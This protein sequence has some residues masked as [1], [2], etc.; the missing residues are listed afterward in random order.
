MTLHVCTAADL[1]GRMNEIQWQAMWRYYVLPGHLKRVDAAFEAGAIGGGFLLDACLIAVDEGEDA[2][3]CW[4][5]LRGED[6]WCGGFGVRPDFRRRGLGKALLDGAAAALQA[7]GAKVW[8][9]EVVQQNH[10][11]VQSYVRAGFSQERDLG[12]Y[13]G[14]VELPL[15]DDEE[16]REVPAA[17]C[18]A[19]YAD[20][21]PQVR[22]TW[23]AAPAQLAANVEK[24]AARE[25]RAGGE[26]VAFMLYSGGAVTDLG[27]RP[28]AA[29]VA[30]VKLIAT[31][32]SFSI[33]N[34]P[35]DDPV[36][37]ALDATPGARCWVK[38]WEMV[39]PL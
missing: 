21:W 30:A 23:G 1:P 28:G 39:L 32:P 17:E 19:R 12:L 9:L 38:Q 18:L 22:R 24:Y 29:P 26:P 20:G 25:L 7:H 4:G 3:F 8:R 14:R 11:A 16:V 15:G 27:L 31:L 33:N 6:A 2:G 36:R 34:L 5:A 35:A 13:R 37:A 10:A